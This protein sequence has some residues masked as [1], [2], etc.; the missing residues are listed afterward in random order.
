MAKDATLSLSPV[1][2][3][4]RL[5]TR[6][7]LP[8][9]VAGAGGIA[10]VA[11][12]GQ[13]MAVNGMVVTSAP[14]AAQAGLRILQQGGNAF[15]AAVATAATMTVV[16]PL[17]SGLGGVGGYALVY[18]SKKQQVRALDFVG[19]APAAVTPETFT[20]GARLWDRAH[21]AR[22]SF[23]APLVP[24]SLA[25]WT[26]LHDQYGT[27]TWAQLLAPAIEYAEKG[28]AVTPAV[29]QPFGDGGFG[30]AV[31]RY[32]YGAGIFFKEEK[33]WP[34]A[35]VLKQPDLAKTLKA[36][37]AGGPEVFYGGALAQRFAAYFRDNGGL[38]AT[39]DFADY[40]ARWVEPLHTTYRDYDVYSQPPGSSGMTVL[41]ALN[42]LEQ[43][44]VRA[45]EHNSPAFVHLV[46][47]AMKLAFIDED[48]FNTGKSYAKVPLDRL[49]SKAYAKQQAARIQLDRAQFYAPTKRVTT[50]SAFQHTTN[51][52]VVD[53]DHNVVVIT[54]TL[55]LPAGM[56]VPETGVIFNNGMSYFST[57][58]Q[59]INR[60]EGGQRPR[61][62]M[63][64]TIVSSHGQPYFALGSAGGWTIPQTILQVTLR[65][66]DFHMDAH[67]AVK[68][69]RFILQYLGNS[70]P[71]M[72][73]TDLALEKGIPEQARSAL[74]GKGHRLL[75]PKDDM[76]GM[77]NGI[78]VYPRTN[79]LS[80]G[81]DPRREGHAAAW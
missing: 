55:M 16:E 21:P 48:A 1:R 10:S 71:Y 2:A 6:C 35:D 36:I 64:P 5:V 54:Q 62:V 76:F 47:E 68:A 73:G 41:Q 15:D 63:S 44:D 19:A 14:V 29:S 74:T 4:T 38:L 34:I 26:A 7:L 8:L 72:P 39:K 17:M 25:G 75:D 58:P 53:K 28:F 77:L 65:A 80:A 45:L 12:Q 40:K 79:V 57:D 31:G 20:A 3:P 43:F 27:M 42:I 46:A 11:V 60:V 22:D 9:I 51:H 18:D 32:P 23:A 30:G 59:D 49:L 13:M 33:P 50:S 67:D 70:I 66:L 52:T 61:F 24:G 37:A 69:P 78:M 56:V 81:E